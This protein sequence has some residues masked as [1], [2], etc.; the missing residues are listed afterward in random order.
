LLYA[1]IALS[2]V[3]LLYV[4]GKT[5]RDRESGALAAWIV[6]LMP[7]HIVASTDGALSEVPYITFVLLA[8][9]AAVRYASKPGRWLAAGAGAAV[10]LACT[11]RFD[12]VIWVIALAAAIAMAARANRLRPE[13]AMADLAIFGLCALLFPLAEFLQWRQLYPDPLFILAQDRATA[14]EFFV[15]GRHP[16]WS[17]GFY[18]SY[19]VAFWPLAAF[20]LL[21]PAV[22]GL[23]Y[24]GAF[25]AFRERRVQ[26]APLLLGLLV[27]CGW[28]AFVT[29]RH[30]V[31]TEWRY[32][33]I[34][35]VVLAV[36]CRDGVRVLAAWS[37]S[38][39]PA[40]LIA[41][42]L[43]TGMVWQTLV[44]LTA[45]HDYG[46]VSRKLA[47]LSILRPD[48]FASRGLVA[49][50]GAHATVDRP[51][52]L[53]PHAVLE[54]YLAIHA[55]VLAAQGRVIMQSH[56]TPPG[57]L[58]YSRSALTAQLARRLRSVGY[59]VTSSSRREIGLQDGLAAEIV[60]PRLD[61]DAYA[62]ESFRMRPIGRFGTDTVWE[63]V[64]R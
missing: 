61:G 3:W 54:P 46:F 45:F 50:L 6:A 5:A 35:S 60:N 2:H 56:Y 39:S 49:W 40:R 20:A 64:T 13:I 51:V 10:T 17:I 30:E 47:D 22:G 25:A 11:F 19:A 33:L 14:M 63:L 29:F 32:A 62:W 4:L 24:V 1:L 53:T 52:L 36:F 27:V 44:T 21:T 18:Q 12:G 34:L 38:A 58:V 42:M 37:A 55:V 15:A 23:C 9:I 8:L 57:N 31:L 7:Y 16:R 43:C 59:V 41:A 28:L 26:T 48:Q